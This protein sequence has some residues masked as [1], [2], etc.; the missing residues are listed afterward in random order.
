[1]AAADCALITLNENAMGVISPS[2]LHANLAMGLP[3]LYIGPEGGNV[4]VAVER[5][6]A[7][8]SLRHGDIDG[9]TGFVRDLLEDRVRR[10]QLGRQARLAFEEAYCDKVAL[11]QFDRALERL[12]SG[13]ASGRA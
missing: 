4:H 10:E 3:I 5:F 9:V 6:D 12:V 13:S 8:V 1:M 11:P 2:K 7:G